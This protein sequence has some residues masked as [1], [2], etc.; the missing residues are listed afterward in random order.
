MNDSANYL[1]FVFVISLAAQ[2]LAAFIGSQLRRRVG[3]LGKA[4]HEDIEIVLGATLT[5]LALIIGFSFSMAVTRYDQRKNCEEAEANAIGTAFL[6]ADLLPAGDAVHVRELLKKYLDLR[7]AFYEASAPQQIAKITAD[8]QNKLWQAILPA[9]N[10]HPTPNAALVVAGIN[11]ALST[12]GNTQA[13]W[14]NRLPAG[15]WAIMGLMVVATNVLIGVSER[16]RG[17]LILLILPVVISTAFLLIA[18]IDE[19]RGGLIH[20]LPHNLIAVTRAFAGT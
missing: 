5:L 17:V 1:L 9:V 20:V 2:W 16:R 12:Q 4:G 14:L 7:I 19:P 3:P 15:V 13:A 10:A 11:D 18:D 6:R 8:T